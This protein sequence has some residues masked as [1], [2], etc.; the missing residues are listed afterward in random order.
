MRKVPF[1]AASAVLAGCFSAATQAATLEERVERVERMVSSQTL[2]DMLERLETLQQEV[3]QLR[4]QVE[5]QQYTITGLKER[6]RELYLDIDRRMSRIEREGGGAAPAAVEPG[7]GAS[8]PALT[9]SPGAAVVAP[10]AAG[11]PA[12]NDEARMQQERE[13]YQQAFDM[14]RE[15]RYAQATAA[16]RDFLQKFPDG[17]YAH[18]AQYW[19]G[20]AGYAQRDFRQAIADYN[21]LLASYPNSPKRAEAMLKVGYSHYELKEAEQARAVLEQLVQ[22]FPDSTEAGQARNLLKRINRNAG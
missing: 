20:E 12:A 3:Q 9:A 7:A 13:A 10:P 18:I 17:R 11:A 1:W 5:E 6:Q 19:L 8:A 22:Q 21:A 2:L 4:G 15:L 14:L 16:F